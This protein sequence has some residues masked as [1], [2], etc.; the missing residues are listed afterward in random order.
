MQALYDAVRGTGANNLVLIS[1]TNW[2]YYLDGVPA[3]RVKGY[4][5][6]YAAH[7]WDWPDKQPGTWDKDWAFLAATDPV[8][9]TEFGNYDCRE[10]YI[11]S[12]MDKADELHLSWVAWAWMAPA[13]G[14]STA[15]TAKG[16]PICDFPMLITDWG[17]TPSKVGK[18]VKDRLASY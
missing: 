3:H 5:L 17:G 14:V 13:P 11:R 2:G 4:N 1:G 6:A 8:V 16:D 9:I 7:P 18:L 12:V 10:G 15:Q